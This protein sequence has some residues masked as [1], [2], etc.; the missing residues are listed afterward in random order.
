MLD[1]ESNVSAT[2]ARDAAATALLKRE[3]NSLSKT[4]VQTRTG[5]SSL[6]NSSDGL[7]AVGRNA[8]RSGSSINQLSGRLALLVKT[9]AA[10]GPAFVP[11]TTAAV[12]AIAG[13]STQIGF[14]VL[15]AG[16]AVLAFQGVG[17]ALK[18]MNDAR[19]KPTT[20]NLEKARLAMEKLS[21]AAR[22]LVLKL[23]DLAPQ[24]KALRDAAS[25]GLLPG[26]VAGLDAIE[27]RLP[28][29]ERIL[30]VIGDALG[31]ALADGGQSLAGGRWDDFFDFI[32]AEARPTL[33][34][35][36][37]SIGNITHG[38]AEMWMA[39]DP[40]SDDFTGGLLDASNA[41]DDWA[42]GL[43]QTEGFQ[44]FIA[45]VQETGPQ[46]LDTV[47]ALGNAVLQIGEAAAP[48]GGPVLRALEAVADVIAEIASSPLGTPIMAAVTAMS[49]LSLASG[50]FNRAGGAAW[51]TNISGANGYVAAIGAARRGMAVGAAS[52]GLLALSLTDVDEKA[53]VSNTAQLALMGTL[54]SPGWGTAIGAGVGGLMDLSAAYGDLTGEI[55]RADAALASNDLDAL[56]A[57]LAELLAL[58]S[59][60][61]FG[62]KGGI[63]SGLLNS[64]SG[65][66][67]EVANKAKMV[68]AAIWA[69]KTSGENGA[70]TFN[71]VFAPSL[72][73]TA[74]VLDI[75]TASTA[76]FRQQF[77]LLNNALTGRSNF[78]DFEAAIDAATDALK[79]NG[80]TLNRDT[81][82]GRENEAAL[83][84]IAATSVKVAEGLRGMNRIRFLKGAREDFIN[85]AIAFGKTRGEAE[86]LADKLH[87]LNTQKPSKPKVDDKDIRQAVHTGDDLLDK[88]ININGYHA[89][90]TVSI[91]RIAHD[92]FGGGN[93]LAPPVSG[94]GRD[95]DP[96]T[97]F[98]DGGYTGNVG[99]RQVAGRVH[100]QEFVVN[101][102]ATA[103]NRAVLEAMN[104]Q[105]GAWRSSAGSYAG[106]GQKAIAVRADI[107]Y[108]RLGRAIVDAVREGS[109]LV[110]L[111]NAGRGAYLSGADF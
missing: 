110:Q 95:G 11:I 80:K 77:E 12:P 16:T 14:A 20:A 18:A 72:G 23:R 32:E 96:K 64:L 83:D 61:G 73:T 25:E 102:D 78:R 82:A 44:E 92:V 89:K 67:D 41:F 107:D 60:L 103:A 106:S 24:L 87:L 9:A 65:N 84:A 104:A 85:T 97:P 42:E 56:S 93:I 27:S 21:P 74:R 1:V 46:V 76:D 69:L 8:G 31:D 52:A 91:T 17:D 28:Q 13:L 7:P 2:M 63:G 37:K 62:S 51:K 33:D 79:R 86:K 6:N 88:L 58:R 71:D 36:A 29:V 4:A 54:I 105:R 45:Y 19:L 55:G 35:L 66:T 34:V 109:P 90:A 70:H 39:F 101:A 81:A 75:A 38:L 22:E 15:A 10:L 94:G 40:L 68:E 99:R 100:G 47:G 53:G 57:S 111:P 5:V 3:L 26:V 59:E 108:V 48:L 50:V 98:Y 43:A 30:G 49:A